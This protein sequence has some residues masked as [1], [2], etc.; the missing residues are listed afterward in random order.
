MKFIINKNNLNSNK[1]TLVLVIFFFIYFFF[2][3]QFQQIITFFIFDSSDF[4]IGI[5]EALFYGPVL[6]L[7]IFISKNIYSIINN[8]VYVSKLVSAFLHTFV[9]F[10]FYLVSILLTRNKDVSILIALISFLL[11]GL[12]LNG[13][14]YDH[15]YNTSITNAIYGPI[16][17]PFTISLYCKGKEKLALFIGS[18][19]PLLHFSI[20][21]IS[22]PFLFLYLF[23]EKKY[24]YIITLFLLSCFN[25]TIAYF[26][27]K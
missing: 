12:S 18:I 4:H 5:E 26:F 20:G 2:G 24:K 13:T 17:L 23:I 9:F 1:L 11:G 14:P 15:F 27:I 19:L 10:T 6:N 7:P 25:L 22:L 8:P 21:I 3:S 16:I